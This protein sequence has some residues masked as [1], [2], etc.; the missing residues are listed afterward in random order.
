MIWLS[1]PEIFTAGPPRWITGIHV[2][3]RHKID[4]KLSLEFET[5]APAPQ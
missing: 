1:A 3:Y 4:D 5:G 2:Y